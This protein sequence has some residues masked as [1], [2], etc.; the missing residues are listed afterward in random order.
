MHYWR[1]Q[2]Q[3]SFWHIKIKFLAQGKQEVSVP[4]TEQLMLFR[5]T[6]TLFCERH[7]NQGLQSQ[8]TFKIK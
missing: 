6:V 4:K 2:G 5:E 3:L 1:G 8:E 7:I